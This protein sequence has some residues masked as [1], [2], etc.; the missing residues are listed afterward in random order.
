MLQFQLYCFVTLVRLSLANN[1]GYLLY[2]LTYLLTYLQ[3]EAKN[4]AE[5]TGTYNQQQLCTLS[6]YTNNKLC[7]RLPQYAPPLTS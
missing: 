3:T 2:L 4:L 5:V 6:V 1:K 7:G